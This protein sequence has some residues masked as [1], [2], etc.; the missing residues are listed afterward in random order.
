M[1]LFLDRVAYIYKLAILEDEEIVFCSKGFEAFGRLLAE[2]GDDVDV[3]FKGG[4]M[5]TKF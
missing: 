4:D 5:G 1:V 2:V 3:G